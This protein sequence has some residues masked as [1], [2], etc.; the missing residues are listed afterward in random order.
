MKR[1]IDDYILML[2]DKIKNKDFD[3]NLQDDVLI[4]INFFNKE[5]IIHLIITLFYALFAI[6][7]VCHIKESIMYLIFAVF[8]MCFLIPYIIYYFKLEARVQYLYKLYFQTKNSDWV[9][10]FL[11]ALY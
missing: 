6:L 7:F 10:N 5:R 9:L 1:Y 3:K 4:K 8:M 11:T 2:E